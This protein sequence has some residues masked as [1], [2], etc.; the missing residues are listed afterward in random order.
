MTTLTEPWLQEIARRNNLPALRPNVVKTLLPV[1]EMQL[2]KIVQQASKFSRRGKSSKLSVEDLN[3][4]LELYNL[5]PIYGLINQKQSLSTS[6]S[7][8]LGMNGFM[9][10][11]SGIV[12]LV[13]LARAPLP[14]CPL[15]PELSLHW[16]AVDGV[17]P[18][19]PENP[20]QTVVTDSSDHPSSLPRELQQ[21]Y[22]RVTGVLLAA[23]RGDRPLRAVLA[24]LR[25]DSGLQDLV[26]YFSKFIYHHVKGNSR[27]LPLLL[28]LMSAVQA[29]LTNPG[30]RIE[31]HLQ[32]LLPAIFTATVA[33]KLSS[34]PYEDHWSLRAQSASIIAGICIKYSSWFPDLQARISKTFIDALQNDKPLPT[35]CGGLLGLSALGQ[36]V[37][38]MLLLPRVKVIGDRLE[39]VLCRHAKN[40]RTDSSGSM[41]KTQDAI[42]A[43]M[44]L[45]A[46]AHAIGSYLASSLRLGDL[47]GLG[48]L[49]APSSPAE[50]DAGQSDKKRRTDGHSSKGASKS[51]AVAG[52]EEVLVPYYASAAIDAA[53]CRIFI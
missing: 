38:R 34:S 27:S 37:V 10:D 19:I 44:C 42:S 35:L 18:L 20:S 41:G 16:L 2:R 30:I 48:S 12:S 13:Q 11:S 53:H 25:D 17:Q 24:A 40:D 15:Q 33:E 22:M 45:S 51:S 36:N 3:Q 31:F 14:K 23:D 28:T 39:P 8:S 49:D 9:P 52:L 29:L 6:S 47:S 1:V 4:A 21:F 50:P 46:L 32:Q 5:E 26:P 7:S 43:E